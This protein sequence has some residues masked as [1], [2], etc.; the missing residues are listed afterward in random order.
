M[1]EMTQE[2]L[3]DRLVSGEPTTLLDIREANEY[4][5]WHIFGSINLPVY[6]AINEG[7]QAGVI[8]KL[9]GFALDGDK[10]VAVVCR[11]GNTSKM[12]AYM[13]DSMGFDAY[14]VAG[15]IYGWS[16]AWTEAPIPLGKTKD[17]ILIQIRRNGK[18]CLSYLFGSKGEAAVVDPCVDVP[19]YTALAEREGVKI[20]HVLETHVHAD[21]VSRAR[22]LCKTTGAK[23]CL[24]KNDR[25]QF[26]YTALA[27]GET[28]TIGDVSV[29]VIATPGHT[30]ESVCF[31]LNGE[32]LVS[33]DT[34]F[35]DN[36]GRPDLEKGDAGAEAGAAALYDSLHNRV[37][38]LK[39]DITICPGHTSD[40][41]GFDG[42]PLSAK[43]AD[44]VQSVEL[45]KTERSVFVKKIPELLGQKPPNFER[46]ISINEGKAELGWLDPLEL[47]AGPNR[48]AVK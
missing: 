28:L 26:E 40:P 7:D 21:H 31:D 30:M 44:I 46:V 4:D 29:G 8:E 12:A 25:A 27:D 17:S 42:T 36:I 43:L 45:L 37:L 38:K 32:V 20:T 23:M 19:V 35:V 48:C 24:P 5:D 2:T 6:N 39:H 16:N 13:L 1:K 9:K 3:V 10:P 41:I 33:G 18:G 47:E 22:E 11:L 15:G 14:S 34:I